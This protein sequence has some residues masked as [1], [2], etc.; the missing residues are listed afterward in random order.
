MIDYN[1]RMRFKI[2]AARK[3]C[4]KAARSWEQAVKKCALEKV[5]KVRMEMKKHWI[6]LEESVAES[7]PGAGTGMKGV[8]WDMVDVIEPF[9]FDEPDAISIHRQGWPI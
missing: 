7:V 1:H 9:G 5:E 3:D 6:T 8:T 2:E 4:S